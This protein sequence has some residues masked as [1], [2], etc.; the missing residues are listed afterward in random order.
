MLGSKRAL[1]HTLLSPDVG[2]KNMR[3]GDTEKHATTSDCE[4]M[5]TMRLAS[6][7]LRTASRKERFCRPILPRQIGPSRALGLKSCYSSRVLSRY[8]P[9]ERLLSPCPG[10]LQRTIIGCAKKVCKTC[11][12]L[13]LPETV[14]TNCSAREPRVRRRN[15]HRGR[16]PRFVRQTF[17]V[18]V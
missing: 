14:T 6:T 10:H 16:S 13:K 9:F 8:R 3:S 2:T 7:F 18:N 4:V 15:R 12:K 1:S 17:R 5:F 11:R